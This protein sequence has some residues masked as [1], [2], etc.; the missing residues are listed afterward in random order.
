MSVKIKEKTKEMTNILTNYYNC[1]WIYGKTG[2]KQVNDR[3]FF[4]KNF[5]WI[6]TILHDTQK[7]TIEK[8]KLYNNSKLSCQIR[9][10][11]DYLQKQVGR[12]KILN[13][14]VCLMFLDLISS[15]VT[16]SPNNKSW[17]TDLFFFTCLLLK[18]ILV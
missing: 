12:R 16:S 1:Q 3:P 5:I 17:I 18:K 6:L 15:S 11:Q 8:L 13:I 10:C 14:P 2:N 9:F 4:K 7:T